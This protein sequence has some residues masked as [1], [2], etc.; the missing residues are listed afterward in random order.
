MKS[1]I[2]NPIFWIWTKQWLYGEFTNYN[3]NIKDV[4]CVKEWLGRKEHASYRIDGSSFKG[5]LGSMAPTIN[6]LMR[7]PPLLPPPHNKGRIFAA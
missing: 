5:M 7:P 6:P 2:S 4:S 1:Q 3:V